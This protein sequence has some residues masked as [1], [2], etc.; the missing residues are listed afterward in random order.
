MQEMGIVD[1]VIFMHDGAPPHFGKKVC[2]WLNRTFPYRWI[3]REGSKKKQQQR[4]QP[5]IIWPPY[6]P[7]LTPCDYFLW[8][9][10]KDLVYRNGVPADLEELQERI[11]T[12][13]EEMPQEMIDKAVDSFKTRLEKCVKNQGGHIE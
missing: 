4:Y 3:G 11:E 12:I 9:Y 13:F 7:D 6:S 5:P 2:L 8:G 1:S 10:V